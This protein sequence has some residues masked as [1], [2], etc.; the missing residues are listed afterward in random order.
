ME[1]M[2]SCQSTLL[3]LIATTFGPGTWMATKAAVRGSFVTIVYV[4]RTYLGQIY[5]GPYREASD[6]WTCPSV[7]AQAMHL[8]RRWARPARPVS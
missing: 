3:F 2:V 6:S 5:L 1:Q 4:G 7:A 8:S